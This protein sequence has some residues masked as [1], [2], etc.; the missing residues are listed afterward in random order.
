MTSM[1]IIKPA[2]CKK[3]DASKNAGFDEEEHHV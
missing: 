1:V 3:K 2:E